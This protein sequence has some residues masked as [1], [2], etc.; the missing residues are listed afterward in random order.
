MPACNTTLE[1]QDIDEDPV[2]AGMTFHQ[3]GLILN[4]LF[5][6]ISTAI[7]F[8]LMFKHATHYSKPW[9]QR[10]YVPIPPGGS[11]AIAGYGGIRSMGTVL[12]FGPSS[13]LLGHPGWLALWAE[14]CPR[15]WR[16]H[17]PVS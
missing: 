6:A 9:E 2:V 14:N 5:A 17:L 3:L 7:S 16:H 4:A 12:C 13:A 8:F 1:R 15:G 11:V 10:Q